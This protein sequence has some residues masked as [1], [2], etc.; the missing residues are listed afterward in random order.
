MQPTYRLQVA[1]GSRD[2]GDAIPSGRYLR[3]MHPVQIILVSTAGIVIDSSSGVLSSG[4][5]PR[6]EAYAWSW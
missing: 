2:T 1:G 4:A 3:G 5:D 6:V